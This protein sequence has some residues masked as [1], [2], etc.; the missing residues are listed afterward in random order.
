[1]C[2][3]EVTHSGPSPDCKKKLGVKL[4]FLGFIIE[5]AVAS[6]SVTLSDGTGIHVTIVFYTYN[7]Q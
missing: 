1:M 2:K 3:F 4:G 7:T 6:E 5:G